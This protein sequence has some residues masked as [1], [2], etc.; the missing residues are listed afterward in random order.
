MAL[1]GN[2]FYSDSSLDPGAGYPMYYWN[3]TNTGLVYIRAADDSGWVLVGDS[4]QPHLGQ[5]STQGGNMNG[6]ITGAHGLSPVDTNNFTT[7]LYE[8]GLEV[9]TLQYVN[10]QIAIVNAS[11]I[12]AYAS[13]LATI[14][15]LNLASKVRF[16]TG[17]WSLT[18]AASPASEVISLPIYTD[19]VQAVESECIWGAALANFV[20][21][22]TNS[23]NYIIGVTQTSNR[24]YTFTATDGSANTIT[25]DIDWWII[26]FRS[27][28]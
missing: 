21:P 6:T 5:L 23:H 11:I 22:V 24:N 15:A 27:Q 19:G 25:A 10:Q 7:S 1:I 13:A 26:A 20:A 3:Q 18:S 16:V 2:T 17:T 14:P 8:R 4:A 12:T 28:S 9:A